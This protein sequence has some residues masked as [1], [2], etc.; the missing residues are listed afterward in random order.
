MSA[1]ITTKS[2]IFD[3]QSL[4]NKLET[5][6]NLYATMG[7]VSAWPDSTIVPAPIDSNAVRNYFY[8]NVVDYKRIDP[9]T[10]LSFG[11]RRYDWQTGVIYTQFD[12]TLDLFAPQSG[13]TP[14]YVLTTDMNVYK[15]ISNN[16]GKASWVNPVG[17]SVT[18]V[19]YSDGYIWKYMFSIS[20]SN[21]ANFLTPAFIPVNL[22][23][24]DDGSN[25][26]QVQLHAK[27]GTIEAIKVVYAGTDYLTVPTVTITGDGTGATATAILYQGTIASIVVTNIG[28]N[29]TYATAVVSSGFATISPIVSPINGHGSSVIDELGA[30]YL[31]INAVFNGTESGVYG[32]GQTFRQIGLILNPLLS[33][34]TTIA[35]GIAYINTGI[36]LGTGD[37]LYMENLAIPVY[38]TLSGVVTM[39]I[40]IEN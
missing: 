3:T 20:S 4:K 7:K 15:C 24:S 35:T 1:I 23:T 12:D 32:S 2:R 8:N 31:I 5:P 28:Q 40:V 21:Q 26:Y 37:V 25:Q 14:F 19:R 9:S 36:Q 33:G 34:T 22:L 11:I 13:L 29:Y 38:K 27:K 30:Y 17:N 39:K 10:Q 18:S 16:N 6:Q